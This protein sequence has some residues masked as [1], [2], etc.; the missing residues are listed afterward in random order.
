[1]VGFA[2]Q[3]AS[4]GDQRVS[5]LCFRHFLCRD[6]N[7]TRAR[8]RFNF[9]LGVRGAR[10]FQ[11]FE[12]TLPQ[13]V[14]NSRIEAADNQANSYILR[15]SCD[16][17]LRIGIFR[18]VSFVMRDW[19]ARLFALELRGPLFKERARPLAHILSRTADPKERR[20]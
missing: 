1:M 16:W 15:N 11:R 19:P 4:D 20:L 6:W 17:Q 10:R 18:H 12:R 14:C 7:F 5:A 3:N 13:S 2:A 8:D 9:D